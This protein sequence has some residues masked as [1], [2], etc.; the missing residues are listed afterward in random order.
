LGCHLQ[1]Q[2]K[3]AKE[4][5]MQKWEYLELE[6]DLNSKNPNTATARLWY[7][8]KDGQYF[9]NS[10]NYRTLIFQ[11]GIEGWELVAGYQRMNHGAFMSY[12]D[13]RLF[14]RPLPE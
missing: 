11:L 3:K 8:K 13:V 14:K 4:A 5:E 6:V 1:N 9:E 10:G 12:K 7:Y 2:V